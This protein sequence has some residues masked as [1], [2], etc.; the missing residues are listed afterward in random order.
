MLIQQHINLLGLPVQDRITGIKGVVTSVCFDL[1]GCV[2]ATIYPGA[3]KD[4]KIRDV[5]WY[6]VSRLKVLKDKPVMARP[7]FVA[8]PQ[9]EGKQGPAEKPVQ[10]V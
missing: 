3:D 2:Q 7:N 6:D 9:A 1:F 5:Q 10:K 8:G 4:G